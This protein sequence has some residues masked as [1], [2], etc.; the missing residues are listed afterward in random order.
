MDI[1]GNIVFGFFL[2]DLDTL[3]LKAFLLLRP[4]SNGIIGYMVEN[5]IP[6]TFQWYMPFPLTP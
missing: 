4:R 2:F 1:V 5:F 6:R 3:S